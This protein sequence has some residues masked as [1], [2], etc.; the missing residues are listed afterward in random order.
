MVVNPK[1][2]RP[3]KQEIYSRFMFADN[4]EG[5]AFNIEQ[6]DRRIYICE[7]VLHEIDK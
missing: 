4:T 5:R 2:V 6:D 3:Y 7:Y 1:F